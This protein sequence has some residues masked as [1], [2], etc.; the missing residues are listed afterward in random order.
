MLFLI[1]SYDVL[2][3]VT[4]FIITRILYPIIQISIKVELKKEN[5]TNYVDFVKSI[6][7]KHFFFS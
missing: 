3:T 7:A 2:G 1:I 5:S 6:L 4:F